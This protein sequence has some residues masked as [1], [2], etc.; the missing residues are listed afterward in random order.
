MVYKRSQALS[1]EFDILQSIKHYL[2]TLLESNII[3]T[4]AD[5]QLLAILTTT[6]I[7]TVVAVPAAPDAKLSSSGT[8]VS[9]Y[10]P[11]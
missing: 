4:P 3:H 11:D 10:I 6:I 1:S 8:G 2:H 9:T 7:A 5:M